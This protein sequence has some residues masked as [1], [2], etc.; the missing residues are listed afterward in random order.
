[1]TKRLAVNL[2]GSNGP[3]DGCLKFARK[4]LA[5]RPNR[6]R[7]GQPKLGTTQ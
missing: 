4:Q 7:A 2:E 1:M 6:M 3:S 5:A